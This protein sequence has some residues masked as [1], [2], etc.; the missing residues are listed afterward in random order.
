MSFET[1]DPI[2]VL[3]ETLILM[4]ALLLVARFFYVMG[5]YQVFSDEPVCI[6]RKCP[7]RVKGK[8]EVQEDWNRIRMLLKKAMFK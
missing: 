7:F 4:V 1:A 2:W 8:T 6:N 3:S 5:K